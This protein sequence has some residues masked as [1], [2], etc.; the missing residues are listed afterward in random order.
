MSSSTRNL[1]IAGVALL[2]AAGALGA[3][4]FGNMGQNLVYYWSPGE[5]LAQGDKAIG[6][7]IRL[8]GMVQPGTIQW[9]PEHTHLNFRVADGV[10]ADSKSVM[11]SSDEI[12]PQM[13]REKIGVVVEGTW[14]K[15]STFHTTRLM[16]KHS[17]EYRPPK[18]G[19]DQKEW[20]KSLLQED[21]TA[22]AKP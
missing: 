18:P 21:P 22:S 19:Q 8:G 14:D 13:F 3:I 4:A 6:P 16:V 15:S 2:L 20:Q 12:P 17:N 9:N 11:V 5:L 10:E 1:V 7:T